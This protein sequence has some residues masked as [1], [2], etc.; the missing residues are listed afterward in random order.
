MSRDRN[1]SSHSRRIYTVLVLLGLIFTLAIIILNGKRSNNQ[2]GPQNVTIGIQTALSYLANPSATRPSPGSVVAFPGA[3]GFGAHSL[4]GRGGK[5]I[6]VTNLNDSGPGSLR[7]CATAQGP[8]ICVFRTGGT[9]T[10]QSEIVVRNPFLTIAGQTAPGGGITLR[11]SQN[12][13]G[14]TLVVST[15]DVVIRD[16][17][18]RAGASAVPN[19]VR[20]SLTLNNGGYNI[21]LD[22]DSLSWATDQ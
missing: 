12:Y 1:R 22:H 15:H 9:I 16:I 5:V 7:E 20:R 13:T 14:E 4:G 19:S 2:P 10:T 21:I 6:E 17:R 18:F 3:E 11:A 8:R